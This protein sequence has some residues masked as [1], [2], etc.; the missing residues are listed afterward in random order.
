V[1]SYGLHMASTLH[2]D[3]YKLW[4]PYNLLENDK[5]N[6]NVI[7]IKYIPIYTLKL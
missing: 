6:I 7:I 4:S 5:S 3:V 2:E 1:D